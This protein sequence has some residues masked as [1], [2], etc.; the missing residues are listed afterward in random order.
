MITW[1]AFIKL[2][3]DHEL[4]Y[5]ASLE[6]LQSESH[7]LI[8][9]E[10]D[11]IID[12]KGHAYSLL[13]YTTTELLERQQGV[14]SLEDVTQLIRAHEFHKVQVCLTKIHFVT[15]EEAIESLAFEL[16]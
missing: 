12:A 11:C 16:G 7:D 8:V 5:I 15:I 1:P 14:Y 4:F 2:E 10:Q 9:G 6:Q 13:P 3:G